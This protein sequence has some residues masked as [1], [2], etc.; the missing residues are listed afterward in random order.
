MIATKDLPQ[1]K[2]QELETTTPLQQTL[3]PTATPTETTTTTTTPNPVSAS[4]HPLPT[5]ETVMDKAD[6]ETLVD[7]WKLELIHATANYCCYREKGKKGV[8]QCTILLL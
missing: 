6:V 4:Q 8:T 5:L 2:P 3:T 7:H 1:L